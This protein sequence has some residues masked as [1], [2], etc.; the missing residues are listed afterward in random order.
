V[1]TPSPSERPKPRQKKSAQIPAITESTKDEIPDADA[2]QTQDQSKPRI[3]VQNYQPPQHEDL[4][5]N[6]RGP[7]RKRKYKD[8]HS[9]QSGGT[10]RSDRL[11]KDKAEKK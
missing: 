1:Y 4:E 2:S 11:N 10:R 3:I 9:K 5:G 6:K 7:S 8:I